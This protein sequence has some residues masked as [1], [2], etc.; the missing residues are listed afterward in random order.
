MQARGHKWLQ[1]TSFSPHLRL[2][3]ATLHCIMWLRQVLLLAG[4]GTDPPIQP[5]CSFRFW[6]TCFSAQP[7]L[8]RDKRLPKQCIVRVKV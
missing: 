4:G 1:V 5:A 7:A 2:E 3:R 6:V 8:E